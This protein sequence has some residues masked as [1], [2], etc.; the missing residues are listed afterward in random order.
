M[1]CRI[2]CAWGVQLCI[3]SADSMVEIAGIDGANVTFDTTD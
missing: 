1:S 3:L 2:A